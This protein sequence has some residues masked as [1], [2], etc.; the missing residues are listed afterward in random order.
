MF[1]M[2]RSLPSLRKLSEFIS[3]V[4][5]KNEQIGEELF[6]KRQQSLKISLNLVLL[7]GTLNGAAKNIE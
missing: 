7:T 1:D 6:I 4:H 2:S 3:D 5:L